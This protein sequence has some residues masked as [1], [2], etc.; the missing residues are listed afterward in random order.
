[1]VLVEPAMGGEGHLWGVSK[2]LCENVPGAVISCMSLAAR[3]IFT[4][5]RGTPDQNYF[6]F[7][8]IETR[9][10]ENGMSFSFVIPCYGSEKTLSYVVDE[11]MGVLRQQEITDYEIILVNDCSPDNV[12]NVIIE[13]AE[14]NDHI[15]GICLAKNFG[16]HSALLAGYRYCTGDYI[17]SLDD[18]GQA[19]IDELYKLVDKLEE[20]YDAVYAYY[21]EI[22]QTAFRRF[23][24]WMAKKMGEVMLGQPKDLN[25]SSFFIARRFVIEEMIRY[26]NAYPYVFGLL[27]RTTGKV[28][29]VATHHRKRMLGK[30]GYSFKKLLALW[31]NGFTAFS[32][33]PLEFGVYMGAVIALIGFTYAVFI[34]LRRILFADV[35]TGWSSIVSIMLILGGMV[36]VMLGLIGEYVGRIYISINNAPQYVI[37]ELTDNLAKKECGE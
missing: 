18:D 31:I 13:L 35:I 27:L 1:M 23:G 17:V 21:Y 10:G 36:L 37:R 34:V 32:V 2:L 9:S 5:G 12:W 6:P 25:A 30:S 29:C 22:K 7:T 26:E 20:G 4:E 8:G 14:H 24:T 33:K 28:A 11:L 3:K 15:K 19:P 16:Q